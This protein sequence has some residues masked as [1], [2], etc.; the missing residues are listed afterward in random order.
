MSSAIW[1][2]QFYFKHGV[3]G[4]GVNL[5]VVFRFKNVTAG[6]SA[7]S[8]QYHLIRTFKKAR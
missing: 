7:E 6:K 8:W 1:Y 5:I 4:Y 3:F 2:A